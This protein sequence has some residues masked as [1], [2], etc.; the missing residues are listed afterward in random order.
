M[1]Y[2][3]IQWGT[4]SVGKHALRTIIER[5]DLELAGVRVYNPAKAGKDAGE[6]LGIDPVGI[7]ATDDP[8]EILALDADCVC[9]TALG[10][11]LDDI[12]KPLDD[13]CRILESGKNVVSSAVEYFAYLGPGNT[14]TRE[15]KELYTRLDAACSVGGSTFYHVGINPGFTMDIWPIT[16]TRLSRRI[17]R[18][19]A[20]EVVDMTKYASKHMV[21][22]YIGF[23]QPDGYVSPL[24]N[25]LAN[26]YDS[27]FYISMLMVADALGIELDDVKYHRE[28]ALADQ[29]IDLVAGLVQPGTTAAMRM[30]LDGMRG[31][32]TLIKFM[33][34]WRVSNDVA[35]EWPSGASRWLVNI[36]GDPKVESE[37]IASTDQDG[38]RAVSLTVATLCLNSLPAVCT[39]APGL[40]NNLT[41][42]PHGGGYFMPATGGAV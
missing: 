19:E 25:Q 21:F 38:G 42:A 14:T 7:V 41:I 10:T 22:D 26:P 35:P 27:A 39:A 3:V 17:D 18:I 9:Y 31:G 1:P 13:I 28:V 11:T 2:R 12:E 40:L 30:H 34:V 37:L 8:E 29:P 36:E 33:Y 23:G 4:G 16:L 15:A 20:T 32:K 6:I 5:P 24:D